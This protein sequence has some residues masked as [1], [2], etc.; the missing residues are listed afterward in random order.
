[1]RP[2]QHSI[3][4][5]KGVPPASSRRRFLQS[6]AVSLAGALATRP[7]AALAAPQ[8]VDGEIA[9]GSSSTVSP[10]LMIFHGTIEVGIIRNGSGALLIDCGDGRVRTALHQFGISRI[11]QIL[12]THYHRDQL[13]GADQFPDS[14]RIA[15]SAD[16]SE[17]LSDPQKYWN[18]DGSIYRV[19]RSFRP[20]HLM[21]LTPVPVDKRLKDG[22]EFAFGEARIQAV[23]T[24]GHTAGSLSYLVEV[25]GKRIL[26]CGDLLS[27]DGTI[28]DLYSLQKGFERG[29][30]SIGGYHGFLGAHWE[31][32]ES[33]ERVKALDCDLLVPARGHAIDKVRETIDRLIRRLRESYENYVSISALRHYFPRLFEEFAGRSGQMPIRAGIEPPDCLRH[34]GTTWMLVSQTGRAFVMDVGSASI[35]DWLDTMLAEEEIKSIDAL[36][37]THYH[38]DHTDGIRKFQKR[39]ACPCIVEERLADVLVRPTAYRLPCLDSKPIR[40][41]RR[42]RDGQSWQWNEFKLT[43]YFYPGQTLYHAALLAEV[44]ELRMLFVG[45][46]HTPA[47]LDDYCAYNRN[48]L[49]ADVGFHYCLSLI[50]KLQPTHLFNCHVDQAFTFTPGEVALMRKRL[51]QRERLFGELTFWPHANFGT[52]PYWVRVTP[53]R[54]EVAGGK[55]QSLTVVVTNH[56]K[57]GR[58]YACRAIPPKEWGTNK[59]SWVSE[60]I[61]GKAERTIGLELEVPRDIAP[62]R[63]VVA[64]DV[65][66]DLRELPRFTECIIDIV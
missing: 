1:M 4:Q 11:E 32:I 54:R 46:S 51:D 13:C 12:L 64:L 3:T 37:V 24:P 14:A 40:V 33:L 31:L 15:A 66:Q 16:E 39:V 23:A 2:K 41:D 29:G 58:R 28:P 25:D 6:T 26:F 47:G 59:T 49:G 38:F 50:E 9:A 18:D 60:H 22:D 52:D 48:F 19:Y 10:H 62:G 7:L 55:N 53:Y 43:A 44:D 5:K 57:S 34:F 63:Y 61:P 36:W 42:V 21:P 8:E 27:G 56:A 65:R 17:Y 45:D 35:V 20:H 30:Q